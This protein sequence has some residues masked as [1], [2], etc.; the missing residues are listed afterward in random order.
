[1]H[2]A[3]RD[4]FAFELDVARRTS[5]V[6]HQAFEAQVGRRAGRCVD[7]HVAHRAAD[8]QAVRSDSSQ[9]LQ[10]PRFAEAVREM[11]HHDRLARSRG[12]RFVN[13]GTRRPGHEERR[14][15]VFP[16]VLDV[17]RRLAG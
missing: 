1:M 17:K 2:I 4:L 15:G 9:L 12:D 10:E 8:R 3:R 5:I 13:G 16:R 11:F 6:S 7:A 14:R